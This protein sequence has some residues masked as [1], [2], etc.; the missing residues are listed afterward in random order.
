M[1]LFAQ[2]EPPI[3]IMNYFIIGGIIVVI[4]IILFIL[5]VFAR[6]FRWWVQSW[7]TGAGI[8]IL[9]LLGMTFRKVNP[10]VIV[11]SKIMAVQ[12]GIDE[13]QGVTSKGLE[14]H[15][16]AGGNVPLVIRSL[17]AAAKAKLDLDFKLAAA[18]DLAGRNI[19]EAVQTSV[20]PKVIDCPSRGLG[21]ESLDGVAQN[22]IQLKVKARVT[23]RANLRQLIGGAT[24][25]TIVARVGEGIVS[26]IGTAKTHSEVL[27]SPD[28]ISKTVLARRLDS[29]TAFEIVSIDIADINVGENIGAR[30]QADQA[31]ADMRVARANAE[32]R[33]A[34]AVAEEQEMIAQ[35]EENRSKLVEA[36]A[37]VPKAIA[38]AF[39]N[40]QLGLME[41][42]KLRNIQA[43]TDMRTAI[44]KSGIGTVSKTGTAA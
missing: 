26:A 10:D 21:K 31:E 13:S 24:E 8:G 34:M 44:A 43:D 39:R 11:R 32:G 14:A 38:D 23:V 25:E 35:I 33:R 19:L 41:F 5:F 18:I 2:P 3:N 30:L 9:D 15:Y 42:Y 37:E 16:L 28:R 17:I 7:M 40:R 27:A 12:A 36:E 29:Q 20:N 4:I 22:G 6:F 1:Y